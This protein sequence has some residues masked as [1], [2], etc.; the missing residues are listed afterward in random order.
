MI[1]NSNQSV[2]NFIL[3]YSKFEFL[4]FS[5]FHFDS[6]K[7][8]SKKDKPRR[9]R[10]Q[11]GVVSTRVPHRSGSG[12]NTSLHSISECQLL[13]RVRNLKYT[14]VCEIHHGM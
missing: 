3:G 4:C 5:L 11:S 13:G 1:L 6:V 12:G 10:R 8:V 7:N 2:A 9:E 14:T